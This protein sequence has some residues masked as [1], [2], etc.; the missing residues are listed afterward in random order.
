MHIFQIQ[1]VPLLLD[2]ILTTHHMALSG[3]GWYLKIYAQL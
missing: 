1:I 2:N 3:I